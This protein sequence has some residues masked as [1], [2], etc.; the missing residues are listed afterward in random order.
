MF[1]KVSREYP[2]TDDKNVDWQALK[3]E[4]APRVERARSVEDYYRALRDFSYRIPD[5]HVNISF[6]PDVFAQ[7]RG[8]GF[9]LLLTQLSDGSVIVTEVIPGTS[10]EQAGIQKGA[11]IISWNGEPVAAAI[12]KVVP[13][14][15]PY[16]TQHAAQIGKVDF[17]GRVPPGTAITVGYKN[18]GQSGEQWTDMTAVFEYDSFFKTLAGFDQDKLS[19]PIES[20]VL[21]DSNL[22]Y[23]KITTF[24]DDYNLM[25]RLWERAIQTLIDKEIPG[26]IIDLRTNPGGSPGLTKNFAGYFFDHDV[27]LYKTLYYNENS[28][29][30]E[31]IGEPSKI[32]PAPLLYEGAIAVLVSPDCVSACE[33]FAYSLQQEG[34]AIIVGHTPTA[35]A[36]GE[37]GQGQYKLPDEISMQFPTGRPETP[38]GKLLIEGQGVIPDILVPLTAE[39]ALGQVDALL[40]AAIQALLKEIR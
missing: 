24:S 35:G 7:E 34:R 14:L 22:G 11:E 10:A 13:Y 31:A 18:P 30:F 25:A 20:S 33:G 15:G 19:L 32:E 39:S 17:L 9:G 29:Q 26:L 1:E 36:F 23:I 37:V 12:D 21:E 38:D 27:T 2:F 8:G 4:F 5:G 40:E 28:G 16:S 6:N 3:E